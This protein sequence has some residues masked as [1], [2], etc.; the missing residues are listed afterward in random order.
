MIKPTY[1]TMDVIK[2]FMANNERFNPKHVP[3]D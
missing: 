1:G 2:D 3:L